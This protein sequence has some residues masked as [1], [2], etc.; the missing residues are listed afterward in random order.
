MAEQFANDAASTLAANITAGAT[1]LTLASGG[2]ADFPS[3]GDF[4]III[5]SEII[6]VGARTTDTLSTLTRGAEST[7]A[8]SHNAGDPVTHV[9]TAGAIATLGGGSVA[10]DAIWDAKGDLA[11]GTGANAASRLAVGAN[12]TILMAD[13]AQATGL[14]WVASATP[15]TSA[16]GDAAAAGTSDDF[17]RG[18]HVHGRETVFTVAVFSVS[19]TLVTSTGAL[20]WYNRTG[21]TLT[22]DSVSAQVGTAP[23]GASVIVDI[24]KAGTTIY[25]TQ[26]N[27]PTIAV[28]TN[29]HDNTTAPDVATIA[30]NDYLTMDVDQIG[31]TVA[32]SN[33][34]VQVWLRG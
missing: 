24:H 10:T 12:D 32:G 30:D 3:T 20:R 5:G 19:G 13:S 17:A 8:A 21:R 23:T 33:L 22:F 31:S 27:R 18:S 15:T 4:R 34:V 16:S 9:L 7:T 25:T 26:A 28:S 29:V 14:K 6:I 2:G 11:G 1:S